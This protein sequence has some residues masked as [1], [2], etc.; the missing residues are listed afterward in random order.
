MALVN[1]VAYGNNLPRIGVVIQH[2][3][4]GAG[5]AAAWRPRV[6]E[7]TAVIEVAALFPQVAKILRASQK[8]VQFH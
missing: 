8:E 5:S 3:P 7:Y 6:A 1:P 2:L 4:A